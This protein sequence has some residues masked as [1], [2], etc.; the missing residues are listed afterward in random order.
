MNGLQ[1]DSRNYTLQCAH[2]H[3]FTQW[4]SDRN[5]VVSY[6]VIIILMSF[7]YKM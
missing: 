1:A 5:S 2:T 7:N 3:P 6:V 4:V